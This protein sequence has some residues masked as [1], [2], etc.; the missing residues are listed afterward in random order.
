M[1]S[2]ARPGK[3]FLLNVHVRSK[4]QVLALGEL[5]RWPAVALGQLGQQ[6]WGPAVLTRDT[7]QNL[8]QKLNLILLIKKKKKKVVKRLS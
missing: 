3:R 8:G 6:Q 1:A 4:T 2:A 5:T 7:N